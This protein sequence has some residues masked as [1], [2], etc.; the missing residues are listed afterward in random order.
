MRS[1]KHMSIKDRLLKLGLHHRK[2]GS[3]TTGDMFEIF[4]KSHI[5]KFVGTLPEVIEWLNSEEEHRKQ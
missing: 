1:T 3:T 2:A 4:N 5:T